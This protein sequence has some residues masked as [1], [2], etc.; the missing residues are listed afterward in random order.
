MPSFWQ[1]RVVC[2]VVELAIDVGVSFS[3]ASFMSSLAHTRSGIP[4]AMYVVGAV[5][6]LRDKLYSNDDQ[7]AIPHFTQALPD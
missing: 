6:L 2:H 4:D 1:V 7:V 5:E 3:S